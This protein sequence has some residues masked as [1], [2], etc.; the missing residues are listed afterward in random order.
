MHTEQIQHNRCTTQCSCYLEQVCQGRPCHLSA[1]NIYISVLDNICEL[2]VQRRHKG[3]C[4]HVARDCMITWGFSR[5]ARVHSPGGPHTSDQYTTGVL[6][7]VRE[8]KYAIYNMGHAW[9][10]G[11]Y[12]L[13]AKTE[14][15]PNGC[16]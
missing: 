11:C 6:H 4:L 2:E 14:R 8:M 5:S 7:M 15:P 12:T 13:P 1:Q 16:A 3:T 9:Q 10:K